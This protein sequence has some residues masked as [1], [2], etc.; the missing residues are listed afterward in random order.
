MISGAFCH[1]EGI[2]RGIPRRLLAVGGPSGFAL[3][4]TLLLPAEDDKPESA[5]NHRFRP[6]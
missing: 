5:E 1:S 2:A 3:R 6:S 4:M